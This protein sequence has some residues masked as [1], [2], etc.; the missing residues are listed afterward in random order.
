MIKHRP[1][2]V[3]NFIKNL[4]EGDAVY[5]TALGSVVIVETINHEKKKLVA[6]FG[7]FPTELPFD[8]ISP[9]AAKKGKDLTE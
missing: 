4:K 5:S 6:K 1:A 7:G 8:K 9:V 2:K 3:K